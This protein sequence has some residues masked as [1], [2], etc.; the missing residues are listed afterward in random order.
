MITCTTIS[1]KALATTKT[2]R[3]RQGEWP[4]AGRIQYGRERKTNNQVS[5]DQRVQERGQAS[6]PF[7]RKIKMSQTR[8]N[9]RIL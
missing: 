3:A 2:A 1:C 7:N 8:R 5:P 6:S 4:S 9:P